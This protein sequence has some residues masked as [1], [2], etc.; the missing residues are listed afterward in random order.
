MLGQH[1]GARAEAD[2]GVVALPDR[3][4]RIRGHATFDQPVLARLGLG[5][6]VAL[7]VAA[8]G[9]DV[10]RDP[11]LVQLE[12]VLQP[13]LE[14]HRRVAVVLRSAQHHDRVRRVTLVL[15]CGDQ[16][17]N[18][19]AGDHQQGDDE[20][21]AEV[22]TERGEH[23]RWSLGHGSIVPAV[24]HYRWPVAFDPITLTGRLVRLTP[25][26]ADHHA[27][28]VDATR[29]GQLWNLHYTRVPR[30]DAMAAEIEWRLAQQ[31]AGSMLPFTTWRSDVDRIIGMTTF[32]NID[33]A[34]R[35]VE[36]G[37]TWNAASAQRTGTNT[38]SKLLLLEHAFDR[39]DC[40]AVEF[41]TSWF[42]RQSQLAIERLGAKR[43]GVLR[44]H[45]IMP[46]GT[47]RDTVVY[48]IIRSEWPAVRDHLRQLL[49]RHAP[50]VL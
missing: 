16:D 13:G 19:D 35:R 33:A 20:R 36:I 43:D 10:R 21:P 7:L 41:R 34:N 23:R 5:E 27:G 18:R 11:R 22:P 45:A 40:I 48:S 38:E 17:P 30:P 15:T 14:D 2:Q 39:L 6:V 29:D 9:D 50:D 26:S 47:L 25:L 49:S 24:A 42:N 3:R 1:L 12:R 32:C 8:D 37:Y 46:D 44:N 4:H 28:L 31:R